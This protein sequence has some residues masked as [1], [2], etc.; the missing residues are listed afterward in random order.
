MAEHK[1]VTPIWEHLSGGRSKRVFTFDDLAE[2]SNEIS[3]QWG[4][5][6]HMYDTSWG[7][8]NYGTVQ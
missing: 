8:F 6:K 3:V 7:G 1:V 5:P 4:I 2:E